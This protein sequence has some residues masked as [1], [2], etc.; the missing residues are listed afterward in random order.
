[1]QES[2]TK[3]GGGSGHQDALVRQLHDGI[4]ENVGQE[5]VLPINRVRQCPRECTDP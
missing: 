1:M 4:E 5:E 3:Q 2:D